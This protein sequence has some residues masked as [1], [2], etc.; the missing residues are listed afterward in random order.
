MNVTKLIK[1][2][3]ILFQC[4]R[5]EVLKGYITTASEWLTNQQELIEK[6][7][8]KSNENKITQEEL[9]RYMESIHG[10]LYSLE[11]LCKEEFVVNKV[12][13]NL[14]KELTI[15]CSESMNEIHP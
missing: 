2:T 14:I 12:F 8:V 1:S 5:Q 3:E 9:K 10:R 15:K 6:V 4:I 7:I 13:L 11:K